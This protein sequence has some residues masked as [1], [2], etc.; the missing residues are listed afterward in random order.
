MPRCCS[1]AGCKS[2]YRSQKETVSTFSLPSDEVLK[3]KWLRKIPTDFSK[4]KKP[5]ICIKHFSEDCIIKTEQFIVDGEIKTF[6]RSVP[7][8]KPNAV[9]SIFPNLPQYLTKAGPSCRRLCDAESENFEKAVIKSLEDYRQYEE[10]N[11]IHNLEDIYKYFVSAM[12]INKKQWCCIKSEEKLVLC[13]IDIS[14][15][16]PNIL[17]SITVNSD[18]S[19]LLSL[20]KYK[21]PQHKV[22]KDCVSV[23]SKHVLDSLIMY[24]ESKVSKEATLNKDLA[25]QHIVNMLEE[26]FSDDRCSQLQL[27]ME[28][29]QFLTKNDNS[30]RYC[31]NTLLFAASLYVHSPAAYAAV[32]SSGYMYL[33]HPCNVRKLIARFDL[34]SLNVDGSI[35]YLKIKKKFLKDHEL[36]VNVLLD[37]I[38]IEPRLI[39]KG[40]TIYG[41]SE[42]DSNEIAKTAQ[43]FML[44][45]VFSKFKDVV[46]IVPVSNLTAPQL[47]SMLLHVIEEVEKVGFTVLASVSDNN[48]VNRKAYE[49][50][51]PNGILQPSIA[52]P[53]DSG[54]KLFLIFDTV[55]I[56][57]CI[58]NNW[59]AKPERVLKFPDFENFDLIVTAAFEYLELMYKKERG[60]LVKYGHLLSF[61][62]L[63]PSNIQKQ[64]VSLALKI[65]DERTVA[66]LKVLAS[67]DAD[68]SG[69][70][71]TASFIKI[72]RDWWDIVNVK[73]AYEGV[74]FNN[75]YRHPIRVNSSLQI[76][77]LRKMSLWL[78]NWRQSVPSS[79]S[80]SP[81]TFQSLINTTDAF[82]LLIPYLFE[83][84]KAD[85]ILLSK[86]QNDN[87]EGR[88]S[89]YRQLSGANYYVSYVQ[90]LESEK[91]LRFKD[92][93][94]LNSLNK[95]IPL[96]TLLP[97]C[98]T[99]NKCVNVDK[100]SV[101][102]R[103][104]FEMTNIP[105]NF[106]PVLTYIS[107][108]AVKK[109][110]FLQNCEICTSWVQSDK[111]VELTIPNNFIVEYDH[112]RLT[113]PTENAVV[114]T[115]LA[116]FMLKIILDMHASTF[117]GDL[118]Q[119]SVLH[120]LCSI[121]LES[122]EL[123][124][125]HLN[126]TCKCQR[127]LRDLL[128]NINFRS[129]K[130]MI[131]NLTKNVNDTTASKQSG[132]QLKKL[133][134]T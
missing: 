132:R 38:Y 51:T 73:G 16:S 75:Q 133:R 121:K 55:H 37:E 127:T 4:L 107:G 47:K 95:Q 7:K 61:K 36:V 126:D 2:N 118:H 119:L 98:G 33:P 29:I 18:L 103:E 101:V 32:H 93:L 31:G 80:L 50:L 66:A 54:R 105:E 77:F 100:Y 117:I 35:E 19:V 62:A 44:S 134:T 3:K 97:C 81:Q 59:I 96:R 6:Q 108:Y 15:E 83:H 87:L 27:I 94:L 13:F 89:C 8:L 104:D 69:S 60:L 42:T 114:G 41:A 21:I 49:L 14:D 64:N 63:F 130:V 129:C 57:K 48:A 10:Q 116:W 122:C 53:V 106:L 86:F 113:V 123:V 91:K 120:K 67:R 131:N 34:N 20:S 25:I 90:I 88:F 124:D 99:Y 128:Q 5:I 70:E 71:H 17:G 40:D 28:Q 85:Y 102:L 45:S 110:L 46:T 9:P 52:H 1:V 26:V 78:K 109:E 12:H 112:G 11:S 92:M 115:A 74:R 58:R 111:E 24:V 30:R 43:V 72:I 23:K 68:F 125:C 79:Q 65:F 22:P 82:L 56:L 76:E 39:F 84:Y